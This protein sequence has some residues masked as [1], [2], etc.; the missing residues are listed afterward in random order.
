MRTPTSSLLASFYPGDNTN[1][2]HIPLQ[3][4]PRSIQCIVDR[5][6]ITV[7]KTEC[8]HPYFT[9][10]YLPSSPCSNS[11]H[12]HYYT[13]C[14]ADIPRPGG[15]RCV[16]KPYIPNPPTSLRN[17]GF[18][19]LIHDPAKQNTMQDTIKQNERNCL[20]DYFLASPTPHPYVAVNKG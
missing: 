20:F 4:F 19:R 3:P 5:R 7:A 17:A 16:F 15:L 2:S 1:P 13:Q 9:P 11:S 8:I 6:Q 10:T 18:V 12:T 14:G